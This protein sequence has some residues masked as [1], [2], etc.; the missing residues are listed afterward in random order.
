MVALIAVKSHGAEVG[1]QRFR[2]ASSGFGR[3]PWRPCAASRRRAAL[4]RGSVTYGR[5]FPVPRLRRV[6]V[7][8]GR[9]GR[10]GAAAGTTRICGLGKAMPKCRPS[11]CP[12]VVQRI[13][14]PGG[15]TRRFGLHRPDAPDRAGSARHGRVDPA[16]DRP[17]N[18]AE[19]VQLTGPC[20]ELP[21]LSRGWRRPS[22][23]VGM[24]RPSRGS[25]EGRRRAAQAAGTAFPPTGHRLARHRRPGPV[26]IQRPDGPPQPAPV[27]RSA[28]NP[29]NIFSN[30]RCVVGHGAASASSHGHRLCFHRFMSL[31]PNLP[32]PPPAGPVPPVY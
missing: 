15:P 14:Q 16:A 11:T 4:R 6:N 12:D 10:E 13:A 31:P 5:C 24:D 19:P 2:I 1:C 22:L 29:R 7:R 9:W 8:R 21:Q 17:K 30:W 18:L 3:R 32:T 26:S 23:T 27:R 20:D 25:G 28:R